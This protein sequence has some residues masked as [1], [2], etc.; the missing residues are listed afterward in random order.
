[1]KRVEVEKQECVKVLREILGYMNAEA[2]DGLD[3]ATLIKSWIRH[4]TN[5]AMDAEGYE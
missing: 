5:M 2:R 3:D 4:I 1:M